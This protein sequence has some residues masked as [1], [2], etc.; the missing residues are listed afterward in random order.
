MD[1]KG[2][3]VWITGASSGIG[4]ALVFEAAKRGANVILSARSVAELRKIQSAAGLGNLNS[5]VLPLDLS[6]YRQ[7]STP[8]SKAL[9]KFGSIDI[10]INN[11]GIS[12]RALAHETQLKVYEEIMAVNYFGNIALTL[13]LL[14]SM[15]ARKSG[16]V[17]MQAF[18][19][20]LS[21]AKTSLRNSPIRQKDKARA[22]IGLIL[23]AGLFGQGP[24]TQ[25]FPQR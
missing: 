24:H 22:M 19:D 23:S 12:Q 16:V 1:L 7:F 17:A 15:R 2:K 13:A 8:V 6:K 5:L 10:L 20:I 25:I 11:G 18:A 21:T 4:R 9:K 14:P 3:T